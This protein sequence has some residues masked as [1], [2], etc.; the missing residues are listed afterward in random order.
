MAVPIDPDSI[1]KNNSN[2]IGGR[3]RRTT[4]LTRPVQKICVLPVEP[5]TIVDNNATNNDSTVQIE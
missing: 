3:K 2:E 5:A 4:K 1:D